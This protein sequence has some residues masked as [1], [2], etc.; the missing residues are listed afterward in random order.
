M[1]KHVQTELI[2]GGVDLKVYGLSIV[3]AEGL[4]DWPKMKVPGTDWKDQNYIEPSD[5]LIDCQYEA[6]NISFDCIVTGTSWTNLKNNIHEIDSALHFDGYKMLVC[7]KYSLRGYIVR[8]KKMIPVKS[9]LFSSGLSVAQ[10]KLVFEEPQP[11]NIQFTI[12][13]RNT[14]EEHFPIVHTFSIENS[15]TGL[16]ASN[17]QL[18]VKIWTLNAG[19][20]VNLNDDAYEGEVTVTS[21]MRV[22]PVVITGEIDMLDAVTF[23]SSENIIANWTSKFVRNGYFTML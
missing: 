2:I 7:E 9:N 4:W 14:D 20:E 15:V 22:A 21:A 17:K 19:E 13:Q 5:R 6:R 11:F 1:A 12:D 18:F 3:D 10:F 23:S 8:L 16:T